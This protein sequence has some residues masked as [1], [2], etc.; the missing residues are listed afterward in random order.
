MANINHSMEEQQII[1]ERRRMI[2][3]SNDRLRMLD[4]LGRQR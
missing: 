3:R 2:R 4:E 1:V